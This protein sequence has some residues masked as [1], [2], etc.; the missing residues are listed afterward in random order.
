MHD[1]R[2]KRNRQTN[3]NHLEQ[4]VF[5][6]H[7]RHTKIMHN[8]WTIEIKKETGKENQGDYRFGYEFTGINI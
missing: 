8:T 6:T 7:H 4:A 5:I 3:Q 1:H 2:A